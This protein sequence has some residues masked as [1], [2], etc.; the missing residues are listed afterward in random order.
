MK[1]KRIWGLV[2]MAAA[3]TVQA[4]QRLDSL[5]M[6]VG[7]SSDNQVTLAG[8]IDKVT[9]ERMNKGLMTNSLDA[10]SGQAAGVQVQ[11]GG[12]QEAM[13]SA[14]RVR[15]TTSLTGGNDPLVIIDGVQSDIMTLS[16][17]FPTD[18][19]SFTILKDASETAQYGSRGAAG[20]IEVATKKGSG[21]RFHIA[22]DGS[23][24]FESIYKNLEMLSGSEFRQAA[25][26][27]DIPIIDMG[28]D[29]DFTKSPTR[30]GFVHTHHIAFGGGSQN[31]NYR[32]SVAVMDHQRVI[33][34]NR[35][36]NYIAKLDVTQ[37]AFDDHLT[38]DLGV[39]GSLQK[40]DNIPFQQKLFYSAAT[41]NPTF[42]DGRNEDG[43][44]GQVTEALWI[45]NPNSLLEMEDSEN[46]GHFNV[47]LKAL[48]NL[49]Y[50]LS[51]TAFGSFTYN[52]IENAHFYP[53]FVWSHGEAYRGNEKREEMLGNISLRWER[54]FNQ[55]HLDLMALIEAG[56]EKRKGFYT[57]ATNIATDA[58]GYDNLS[59]GAVRPWE[60]TNS[61][62]SDTHM[63]SFLFRSQYSY[64]NR[65]TL[66]LNMRIDGSSK[67][68]ANNRWGYFPSVNGAWIVSNEP[69]MKRISWLNKLKLR[70]GYGK[71]GNLGGID[72]YMSQQL[73][74]PNGVVN[75]GGT[76]V[77]TLGII[78]NANPD[79]R[80][81]IKRTFNV[82]LDMAFWQNRIVLTADFYASKTTDMLYE[83]DV[84]VPPFTYDKLLAN[85]GKMENSGVELGFGITPLRTKDAELSINMNW[86]FERNKLITLNGDYNGQELTAPSTKGI[87]AL[88]GAGFHGSSDVC[89]Q[90][91]GQPLG[92]FYLY[93]CTGLKTNPDGSKEYELSDEKQI[94][95]QATPKAM[96]GSNIAFRYK[97]WDITIQMNGAFGHQIYNG[98][99]LTYMNMLSLPNYNVMKGAPEMNIQDQDISDYWLE[100]GDYV[101][102]DYVTLGWNV[103]LRSKYIHNLR[104]SCS[105][106]NL[107]TI[108]GYSGLTPMINSSVVNSSLGID[109]KRSYPVYRSYSLGLSIQF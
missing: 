20:V 26:N 14:V 93:H 37:R 84:P 78:R 42:P 46:N 87:S 44:Y 97:Q 41:F 50:G 74:K 96:M 108:T 58:F 7:Y 53:T 40:K 109:D 28:Y 30:T 77:A 1:S 13:L 57:T 52:N 61:Y 76:T 67:V 25:K 48:A 32:A 65:Y 3:M 72:S 16:T 105:V 34:K 22:Y 63:E 8:A 5:R 73:I 104:V 4:Q 106:N 94:C 91:V 6:R 71:S 90:M 33:Q 59:A 27:L 21:E 69:W 92:V 43:S 80:W 31:A 66:T 54:D 75:V 47:H 100:N 24:G 23:V 11:T 55:H 56:K 49:G 39:F 64:N 17:I 35:F 102:I 86:T 38:V 83:Y 60:G 15:G 62:Y 36:R 89:F 107:A 81:E 85:L 98:T 79:L 82:G 88:W 10:L 9:R 2:L 95:G 29:T 45:N 18:I 103:P 70:I 19:E 68:G 101:N 12:N 99:A 51:M